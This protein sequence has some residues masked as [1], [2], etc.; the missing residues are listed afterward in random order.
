M[1]LLIEISK[2]ESTFRELDYERVKIAAQLNLQCTLLEPRI[3]AKLPI[4]FKSRQFAL[5]YAPFVSSNSIFVATGSMFCQKI[6]QHRK[7]GSGSSP[8]SSMIFEPKW[9]G[10]VSSNRQCNISRI[11]A[12]ASISLLGANR[13]ISIIW[14]RFER[15]YARVDV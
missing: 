6:A 4:N 3:N 13:P 12:Y 14:A 2:F 5:E 11:G 15:K 8:D 10:R 1:I 9:S 7:S